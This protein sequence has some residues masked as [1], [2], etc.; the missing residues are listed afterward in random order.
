MLQ[1]IDH[2]VV[3]VRDL[4]RAAADF[5][6][7]GFTV[8]AGGEHVGGATHNSLIA[9]DDGTYFELIAFKEP[10][11]PQHHKW[12]T[13]LAVGEG[14]T[15]YALGSDDLVADAARLRQQGMALDGP[16]D[17]GRRRPDGEQLA[18]RTILLGRGLTSGT[19]QP[20]L[21]FVIEDVTPRALRVPAG[22]A[23]RHRRPVT[24]VAG[25]TIVVGDLTTAAALSKVLGAPGRPS[26]ASRRERD[27]RAL[28]FDIGRQWI[29]LVIPAQDDG[30]L[31]HHWRA[32]GDGP[33]EVVLS[34][35]GTAGPGDGELLSGDTH[36]ARLRIAT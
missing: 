16:V 6:N 5:A 9:F 12:W 22:A 36:G 15:D 4:A 35:G 14:L 23:T 17:G 18:W 28:R 20:A 30:A 2:L 19:E 7:A 3:V 34:E 21:P 26:T 25:V 29:E 13:R 24:R 27:A 8:T 33:Y 11:R 1:R 10:D 32:F 31:A